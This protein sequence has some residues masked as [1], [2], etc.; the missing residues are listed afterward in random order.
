MWN[1]MPLNQGKLGMVKQQMNFPGGTHAKEP[2]CQFRRRKRHE[3]DPWGWKIPWRRNVQY[4]YLENPMDRGDWWATVH[5]VAK[6]Q[7]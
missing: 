5:G 6:S 2:T 4:S 1:I 7:T 3:F